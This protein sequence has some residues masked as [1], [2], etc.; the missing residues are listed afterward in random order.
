MS[1]SGSIQQS[2]VSVGVA[3]PVDSSSVHS[4]LRQSYFSFKTAG[5]P[6]LKYF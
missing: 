2:P 5:A 1:S 3:G 6:L 4:L